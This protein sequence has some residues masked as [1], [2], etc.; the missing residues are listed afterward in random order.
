MLL[1]KIIQ[2]NQ[3]EIVKNIHSLNKSGTLSF[4]CYK[5]DS[6]FDGI[7]RTVNGHFF[8][9]DLYFFMNTL[10]QL[11]ENCT[12]SFTSSGSH[13]TA[14]SKDFTFSYGKADIIYNV[15]IINGRMRNRK[16]FHLKSWLTDLMLTLHI[17][18]F[19][20]TSD[21]SLNQSFLIKF[22]DISTGDHI[23]I[24]NNGNAVTDTENFFQF[25]R[26]INT[27]HTAFSQI[28]QEIHKNINL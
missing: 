15:S 10:Y 21:H 2:G 19:N 25:V 26:N 16:M 3:T 27:G 13:Q 14:N 4:L 23:S 6:C 18:I 8:S 22:T 7:F 5:T 9:I 11:A 24:T 17:H 28:F 20:L 1:W 12:Q